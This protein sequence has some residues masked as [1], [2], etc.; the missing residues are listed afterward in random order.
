MLSHRNEI[1]QDVI[2]PKTELVQ[3]AKFNDVNII[4]HLSK[5]KKIMSKNQTAKLLT[6]QEYFIVILSIF[7]D[8][9]RNN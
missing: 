5:R 6:V 8:L 9:Y 3:Q 1:L 7:L 4:T 2:G